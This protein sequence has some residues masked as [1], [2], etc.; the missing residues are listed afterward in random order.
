[1][2]CLR[3]PDFKDFLGT[4]DQ[5]LPLGYPEMNPA[6]RE[7]VCFSDSG[8]L[9]VLAGPGSGKTFVITQR[10]RYLIEAQ[11]IA[12][13]KILVLTFTK[14]AAL[15]MKKRFYESV[16][17][18]K[19]VNF[20]TFH[21]IFYQILKQSTRISDSQMLKDADKKKILFHVLN[22]VRPEM[23]FSER[24]NVIPLFMEAI[25]YYK[26]TGDLKKT[27]EKLPEDIGKLFQESYEAYEEIRRSERK[28]DFDDML[29]DCKRLLSE[30]TSI[31]KYWQERFEHILIDE[32]QDINSV[33]YDVI[34]LMTPSPYRIFAVGDDDQSIYGFRG[35]D[36]SCMKRFEQD[37]HA[38]TILLNRNYRSCD[39]IVKASLCVI[40]ENKNRFKKE[41]WA[42]NK[43]AG[44][45]KQDGFR[46]RQMQ[47]EYLISQC[48][49]PGLC[50]V[51]FRTNRMMQNFAYML[52]QERIPFVIREKTK[53]LYEQEVIRDVIAYIQLSLGIQEVQS[54][55]R[56]INR[57]SR[58]VDRDAIALIRTHK[59]QRQ[60]NAV[61]ILRE[62]YTSVDLTIAEA[63]EKLEKHLE[64]IKMLSP[65]TAVQYIRKMVGYD[66]YVRLKF[67][68]DKEEREE[69]IQLLEYMT[70][71]AIDW[72]NTQ[73]WLE[74]IQSDRNGTDGQKYYEAQ[75]NDAKEECKLY[76]MTVH[77]AKG[78]EF[79]RVFI[80]DCN[81][82]IFP[83]GQMQEECVLEEERRLFYVGMTR[84]KYELQLLYVA[85]TA[86]D[87]QTPSRFLKGLMKGKK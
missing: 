57:P 6:Q 73:E 78:L 28:R 53:S 87:P 64:R 79:D 36:P 47:Y 50:A 77:G 46:T 1:L 76:V 8:P 69:A 24:H 62:Y 11:N 74:W 3:T 56:I 33:Q 63:I 65:Y 7:A 5:V 68:K 19:S 81:E 82:R 54:L 60:Q 67:E 80:P 12:P 42:D 44:T 43:V 39:E 35:A 15:S 16:H 38:K 85:G 48:K 52:K 84:A 23:P 10:I 70:K 71:D 59:T 32:F 37:Y 83:Y 51:L 66:N 31:R 9:L 18:S 17:S 41:L 14:E 61:S 20:G 49:E 27:I 21:S 55:L 34:K 30:N 58:Y 29:I 13:D 4:D 40:N 22:R 26:N 2:N 86:H 45:V 72:S 25:S 75:R